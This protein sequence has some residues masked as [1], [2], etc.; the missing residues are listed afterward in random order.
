MPSKPKKHNRD[1]E[2]L[3][4]KYREW[5]ADPVL[6]VRQ[7]FR[8]NPWKGQQDIL[9]AIAKPGAHVAVRSGHRCGKT[10]TLAWLMIWFVMC[11]RNCRVPCTAPGAPQLHDV[12]WPE[13]RKWHAVMPEY[14]RAHLRIT[15]DHVRFVG[16]E[17]AQ[18]ATARTARKEQ[19]E[20]LQG[21]HGDNM[22]FIIDEASG[23]PLPIFQVAEGA[24]SGPGARVVMCSNPTRND[25]YFHMAFHK[26][27]ASWTLQHMSS[28]A[29]P[30]V[31]PSY[32]EGM[33]RRYGKESDIYRI[34]VRG[35]FPKGGGNIVL[36]L[37]L[38]EA[39]QAFPAAKAH[40]TGRII[41]GIDIA[42]FGDDD[43]ATADRDGGATLRFDRWHGNATTQSSGRIA[44]G[45]RRN[46]FHEA[47]V[48]TI[49]VGAGVADELRELNL[50]PVADINVGEAA[51]DP[52]F[53]RYRDELYW[54]GREWLE[55]GEA[56]LPTVEECPL[57]ED[58]IAEACGIQYDF[59]PTG[60]IRVE[61][62]DKVKERIGH[63][64]DLTDAWLNTFA[65]QQIEGVSSW[66][67]LS[68]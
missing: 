48:D 6:F 29:S 44:A 12:L 5:R 8:A 28:E 31:V 41:R 60:K 53:N 20:A 11:F 9:H 68:K 26:D 21:F 39:A 25:G 46:E 52:Q 59:T 56:S 32:Y 15:A 55:T 45:F 49:G 66:F 3:K 4:Q 50:F 63:S 37:D 18:F 34:R 61:E 10:T 65:E 42:R 17:Q 2:R 58:F 35:D 13:I 40:R 24:L 51:R 1:V 30:L 57:V 22:L 16:R 54:K 43:S 23:V 67:N 36:P 47:R 27:R 33:A 19:P 14:F 7:M 38:L 62:K 64:P